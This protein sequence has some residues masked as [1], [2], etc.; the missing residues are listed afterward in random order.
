M[1]GE[2]KKLLTFFPLFLTKELSKN[3]VFLESFF[4]IEISRFASFEK[5][6]AES[7]VRWDGGGKEEEEKEKK[8]IKKQTFWNS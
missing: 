1:F 3:R 8:E 4:D 6:I 5:K 2:E 7:G